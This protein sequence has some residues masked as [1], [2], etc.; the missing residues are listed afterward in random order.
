[1]TPPRAL[2]TGGS[3]G[4]G[5][6]VA[7]ELARRGW[8]VT[9][10]AR[11]QTDLDAALAQLPGAGHRALALDVADEAAWGAAAS[12]LGR[13]DGLVCA[14]GV[15]GPIGRIGG[16]APA[17]FESTL[18]INVLGTLLAV[19][20][21]LPALRRS[22]AGAIVTFSGGGATAPLPRFDAY[23]ASKAAVVRLTENLAATLAEENLRINSVA[24]GFVVTR[25][26]DQTLAAGPE[27][28][29]EAYFQKTGQ[30]VA[31]GGV[32]PEAAAELTAF[33]LSAES[34]PVTGKLLSAQWDPWRDPQFQARLA[35]ERDL[36]TL[37]RVDDQFFTSVAR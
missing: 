4:I 23:A 28:A 11:G 20:S 7:S 14:A 33:L 29:G 27:V 34:S 1:M 3:L 22:D 8:I 18:R 32:P 15:L 16:Y 36:A 13:L 9:I 10:V 5:R 21:C 30:Q 35:S 37:R 24:P 17:D 2:V 19:H 31:A 25:M 12:D 26:H 6:A